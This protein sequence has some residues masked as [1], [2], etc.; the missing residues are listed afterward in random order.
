MAIKNLK[1]N[2]QEVIGRLRTAVVSFDFDS[3]YPT[4][5][6]VLDLTDQFPNE[7][8]AVLVEPKNGYL[9]EY[10][11]ANKKIKAMTPL[12][13]IAAHTHA[14][15][16]DSLATHQHAQ[17]FTTGSTA[18]AD[19]T[20]GVLVENAAGSE[21]AVRFMGT[22]ID[23]TYELGNSGA[24]SGGTPAGTNADAGAIS[25]SAAAEVA[26]GTDLSG[27]TDVRMIAFGI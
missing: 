3:S 20:S 16:G 24:T 22:A 18:A 15:T 27:V 2:L 6:E 23:T 9:F 17:N 10:D 14:F 5:G 4:G 25:A 11:R 7:V 8:L 12:K 1:T 21:T 13:A 26:D 19:S